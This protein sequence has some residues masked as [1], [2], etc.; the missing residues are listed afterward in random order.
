MDS[1]KK[2]L[3]WLKTYIEDIEYELEQTK[4]RI[5]E[6]E[7]KLAKQDS[8]DYIGHLWHID[9]ITQ[10]IDEWNDD[11]A[12]EIA[13]GE[14]KKRVLSKED[15]REILQAIDYGHDAT[16]GI[17]WEVIDVYIDNFFDEQE[18]KK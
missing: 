7:S 11:Y 15:A 1:A 14:K 16:I 12:G 13:D 3:I 2:T 17:N 4:E 18:V 5:A 6:L 8:K 10:Q 9:D